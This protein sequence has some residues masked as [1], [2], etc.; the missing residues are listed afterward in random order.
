[1]KRHPLSDIPQKKPLDPWQKR[2]KQVMA[3][4]GVSFEDLA[5]K[6]KNPRRPNGITPG[7]ISHWV[8]NKRDI[9]LHDFLALSDALGIRPELLL[10]GIVL[11]PGSQEDFV[12]K[13]EVEEMVTSIL[14][15]NPAKSPSYKQLEARLHRPKKP[16]RSK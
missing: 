4:T 2:A 6:F 11:K 1:M 15:A 16:K 13:S 12:T 14:Q 10:F 9:N 7:G 5:G 8:N 3:D